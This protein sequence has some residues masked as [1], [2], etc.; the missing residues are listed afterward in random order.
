MSNPLDYLGNEI[1][2]GCTVVYVGA[3]STELL[4]EKVTKIGKKQATLG[5]TQWG[6]Y[7]RRHFNRLIVVGG[8]V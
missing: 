3:G 5:Q 8:A 2:V 6:S 7:V 1:A 4:K